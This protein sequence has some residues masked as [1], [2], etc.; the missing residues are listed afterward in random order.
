MEETD[1]ETTTVLQDIE[2]LGAESDADFEGDDG[3][4][5]HS[6]ST[7]GA[8]PQ[9]PSHFGEDP[10]GPTRKIDESGQNPV[11]PQGQTPVTKPNEGGE[12]QSCTRCGDHSHTNISCWVNS[13]PTLTSHTCKKKGHL[14]R[15]CPKG[16][17]SSKVG[18][19][20]S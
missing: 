20:K 1:V 13:Q 9:G 16:S 4:D 2:A 3:A 8:D 6:S 5:P 14:S 19:S 15:V 7:A 11:S 17:K 12:P 18:G 10:Q